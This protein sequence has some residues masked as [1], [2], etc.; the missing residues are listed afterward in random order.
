MPMSATFDSTTSLP[1]VRQPSLVELRKKAHGRLA[2]RVDP[3]KTRH[4]PLSILRQEAKRILE[5]YFD[6]D[7]AFLAK[8]DRERLIEEVIAEAPGVGVLEDLFRDD[9]IKEILILAHNQV[10]GKKN[11]SWTPTS[12]RFR[13]A[14]QI[15]T[16]LQYYSTI[17]ETL[18]PGSP[19]TSGVDVR[20]TNGF[21]VMAILPPAIMEVAPQVLLV[22]NGAPAVVTLTPAVSPSGPASS[23]NLGA[24]SSTKLTSSSSGSGVL[25]VSLNNRN[26]LGNSNGSGVV[27]IGAAIRPTEQAS[28][29]L[30]PLMPGPTTSTTLDPY[31]RFRQK[32][33]E[34]IV[35]KFASAGM[36][37]LNQVPLAD[38]RRIVL[39][40]V[41]EY[42]DL[43]KMGYDDTTLERLALEILANMNR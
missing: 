1:T 6:Q 38:L 32:V 40:H 21:R 42:C 18:V 2:E 31:A 34:R 9:A 28:G 8:P 19:A 17:G 14:N 5:Q 25:S 22:R 26:S 11:E 27:Q 37:D 24:N 41:V 43:E 13:D 23:A 20:L 16:V 29:R 33:S 30:G 4:K 39:A 15:R 35:I 7:A 36:Y 12:V 3:V 10:I